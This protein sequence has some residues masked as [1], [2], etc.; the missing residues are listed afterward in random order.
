MQK[1]SFCFRI[2]LLIFYQ[3]FSSWLTSQTLSY[4]SIEKLY[5]KGERDS[6]LMLIQN[7]MK[8]I[9]QKDSFNKLADVYN[10]KGN[11]FE[12]KGNFAVAFSNYYKAMK[13]YYIGNDRKGLANAINNTA[14]IFYRKGI[15]E[16]S[17]KYQM[18]ALNIRNELK[19]SIGIASSYNNIGNIYY[20]WKKF[21]KALEYYNQAL[22]LKNKIRD[23]TEIVNILMNIGSAWLGLQK[24]DLAEN[25]YDEALR[26][27]TLENN[28]VLKADG[29]INMGYT[30]FLEKK[31]NEAEKSY[32]QALFISQKNSLK[33]E[34][35]L[36]MKNLAELYVSQ[37]N[38]IQ[39]KNFIDS[40]NIKCKQLGS[41]ESFLEIYNIEI[42]LY[43]HQNKYK[44]AWELQQK[45]NQLHDRLFNDS[46]L[47]QLYEFQVVQKIENEQRE[48]KYK[49]MELSLKNEQLRNMRILISVSLFSIILVFM[50]I[51][52]IIR[53]RY[54][55]NQ[56]IAQ[57]KQFTAIQK[58]LSAQMNPHFISN[59]L[60]SIQNYFLKNDIL[61]ATDYLNRFGFLIRKVL[62]KS[63]KEYISFDEEIDILRLYIQLESLRLEKIVELELNIPEEF[64][65]NSI[66]IPPLL[67][68]PIIENSIWHGISYLNGNGRITIEVKLNEKYFTCLIS[69]NGIGLHKK[70]D[71]SK[72]SNK[73]SY[74]LKLVNERIKMMSPEKS[75]VEDIII[76][77][78]HDNANNSIG[79]MVSLKIPFKY[80]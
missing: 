17:L 54:R 1:K 12:D 31:L 74:G 7:Y 23:T 71:S 52:F 50:I 58:A 8:Q 15:Y 24:Y 38:F 48:L 2:L 41:D 30:N 4:N 61:S 14:N 34:E 55:K 70:N 16:K 44:E 29:L 13:Y 72:S 6:S 64:P 27:A 60:N 69:D 42:E 68:Q 76:T 35:M 19:D 77:E 28:I 45:Y 26:L 21:S 11:I 20:S 3:L 57:Q 75:F 78:K 63:M 62:D 56:L 39:A 51:F 33:Y 43:Y 67:L 65:S 53:I 47:Q 32:K 66:A 9:T 36:V 80:V 25:Y 5:N 73:N 59:S 10:L 79:V 46:S 40:A 18:M 22:K 49:N 37:K